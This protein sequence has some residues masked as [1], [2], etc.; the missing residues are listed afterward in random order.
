[1]TVSLSR[2]VDALRRGEVVGIPTDT[3]YG[4]VTLPEFSGRLFEVKGR[5]RSLELPILVA[6][7]GQA[8]TLTE[9]TPLAGKLAAAY[10]PGKLTIVVGGIGL[11]V[12]AHDVP[13]QLARK[14]GPLASTSA[15]RHGEAPLTVASDVAALPG[16][17][18]VID[19]GVCEGAPSTVVD[20]DGDRMRVI[21]Q[22]AIQL[23]SS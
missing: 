8:R 9:F 19:G 1:M 14:V 4:L 6:D 18:V 15:N 2:A 11:R 5:P 7:V 17:I 10:W 16:V 13:R 3:V 20:C 12:P 21:R 23:P 22:G